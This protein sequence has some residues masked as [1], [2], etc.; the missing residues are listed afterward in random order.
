MSEVPLQVVWDLGLG[1]TFLNLGFQGGAP[2]QNGKHRPYPQPHFFQ[3]DS[4]KVDMDCLWYGTH[5]STLERGRTTPIA[6][7]G[8]MPDPTFFEKK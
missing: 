7:I 3:T 1:A 2:R 5:S 4:S 8:H 6:K